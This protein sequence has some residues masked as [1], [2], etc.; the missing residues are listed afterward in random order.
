MMPAAISEDDV[1]QAALRWLAGLG[2]G[3][4]HGPD[5]SPPAPGTPGTERDTYRNVALRHRLAA[6]VAYR[7]PG[8]QRHPAACSFVVTT[9]SSVPRQEVNAKGGV[10][11]GWE[12]AAGA[13]TPPT[14][15]R[16]PRR[17]PAQSRNGHGT[18]T[19][20]GGGP[21]KTKRVSPS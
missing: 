5:I 9:V 17:A 18:G 4:A 20:T 1:E 7:F 3:V 21:A 2:W 8:C 11:R 6:A 19:S 14:R 16:S 10:P 13:S 12:S 15:P